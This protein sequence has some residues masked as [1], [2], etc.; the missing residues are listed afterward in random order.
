MA[1]SSG[2]IHIAGLSTTSTA[3]VPFT[4]EL[5]S[6]LEEEISLVRE[7]LHTTPKN[8]PDRAIHLRELA[9][10]LAWKFERKPVMSVLFEAIDIGRAAIN[11]LPPDHPDRALWSKQFEAVLGDRF[12]VAIGTINFEEP[13]DKAPYLRDCGPGELGSDLP[14]T[15]RPLGS[16]PRNLPYDDDGNLSFF[17]IISGVFDANGRWSYQ[18]IRHGI[19]NGGTRR[20]AAASYEYKAGDFLYEEDGTSYLIGREELDQHRRFLGIDKWTYLPD[21][22][23]V[24]L[25][26]L[27]G[28][29]DVLPHIPTKSRL[30]A[31]CS[32]IDLESTLSSL[33]TTSNNCEL[34]KILS[35]Y[36]REQQSELKLVDARA[37]LRICSVPGMYI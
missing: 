18:P 14:P 26:K 20:V 29:A 24:S 27:E 13:I 15:R 5:L 16:G 33:N 4:P 9:G 10:R 28:T 34:C 7:V 21:L 25:G 32:N 30:C 8:H 1:Q 11:S 2:T 35:Q 3:V 12:S 19:F 36:P 31:Q 6:K 37:Y 23:L 17:D 22:L